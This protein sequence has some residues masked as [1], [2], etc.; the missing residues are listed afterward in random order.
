MIDYLDKFS[1]K[2]KTAYIVGGLGL[3]GSEVSKA[4]VSASAKTVIL[5]I[6]SDRANTLLKVLPKNAAVFYESFDC[7]D[8]IALDKIFSDDGMNVLPKCFY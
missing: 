8:L 2:N 6:D 3:I 5:D 7:T 4:M 1:L